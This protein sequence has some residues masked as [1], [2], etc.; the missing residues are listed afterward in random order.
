MS[1][2]CWSSPEELLVMFSID[3]SL[4]AA[5]DFCQLVSDSALL[6]AHPELKCGTWAVAQ[7]F[8]RRRHWSPML[9]WSRQKRLLR[10]FF[11]ADIDT[12]RGIGLD[13]LPDKL[14]AYAIAHAA[15]CA[16]VRGGGGER[17]P[18]EKALLLRA[19]LEGGEYHASPLQD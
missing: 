9:F 17:F 15:A 12:L 8:L 7:G 3:P 16:M 11:D 13:V 19:R 1:E 5:Q 18:Y 4:P 10:P 6:L 2:V 14:T